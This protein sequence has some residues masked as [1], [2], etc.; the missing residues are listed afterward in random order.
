MTPKDAKTMIEWINKAGK[1]TISEQATIAE[2]QGYIDLNCR[3]PQNMARE[4][5][6][7]YARVTGGGD[8]QPR[9]M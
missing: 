9:R 3:L 8:Y 7:V 4:L 6:K 1:P 2:C 5:E